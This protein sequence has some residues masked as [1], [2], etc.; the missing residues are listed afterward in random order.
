[1]KIYVNN[2]PLISEAG[3]DT[4]GN[5]NVLEWVRKIEEGIAELPVFTSMPIKK[6]IDK[7]LTD[8]YYLEAAGGMVF[9]PDGEFLLIFRRGFWDLPKGK[10]EPEESAEIAALREVWEECG[11]KDLK[12]VSQLPDTYH[13]YWIKGKRVVKKTYWFKMT[14][15]TNQKTTLQ[16]EEDIVDSR[17]TKSSDF[18]SFKLQTY[19]SIIDVVESI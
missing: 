11:L 14:I 9:N 1:M 8:S 2:I 7:L 16:T 5:Q 19:P 12:I 15:P 10:I 4:F 3:F 17:W 6:V 13:T 18:H